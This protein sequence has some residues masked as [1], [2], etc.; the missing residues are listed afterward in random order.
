MSGETPF[1][2][3]AAELLEASLGEVHA[4]DEATLRRLAGRSLF[5]AVLLRRRRFPAPRRSV[6]RVRLS[7]S[8]AAWQTVGRARW[9]VPAV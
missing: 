8:T 6:P 3:L 5:D 9:A 1:E 7:T 4:V 2:P